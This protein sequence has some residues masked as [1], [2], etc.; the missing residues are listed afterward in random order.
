MLKKFNAKTVVGILVAVISGVGA[1]Y[2][3]IEGQKKEAVIADLIKRVAK[4]EGK[5]AE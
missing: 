5:G 1:F 3:E 2:S 4:L